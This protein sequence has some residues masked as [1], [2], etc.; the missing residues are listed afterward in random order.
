MED[1]HKNVNINI[2]TGAILKVVFAVLLVFAAFKLSTL[3]LSIL[4]AIVIASFVNFAVMKVR[5]FI[6]NRTFA[7]FLIYIITIGIIVGLSSVFIPV[8]V[9]EMST[10]VSQISNYLPNSSILNTFQSDSISGAKEV[11]G[12]ISHNG[13]L[14]EVIKSTKNL[15]DTFSGGLVD[16]IGVAFGGILYLIITFIISFYLSIKEDGIE[17]FLRV[18]LPQK[19]EEYVISVWKRAEL[20]IGLWMQGQ[21]LVGLIIGVLTYLG[22]TIIGVDYSLVLSIF[23][24]ICLLIPFGIFIALPVASVFAYLGGGVTI[25]SLTILFY[26]ILQ[27]FESYLITPLII[28]KV[29]GVSS[30]V[31]ILAVLIGA[32]LVGIWGVL[33]A[34]PF[35]V[36]LLEVF[37]DI[38]KKKTIARKA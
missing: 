29:T 7:V 23:T 34:V 12:T 20:K 35:S 15:I 26:L 5:N 28:K 1:L 25:T 11:V 27:Q 19:Q 37:D 33:L 10:L 32:E 8:F 38:E 4:T 31:V 13:S 30:L 21:M 18:I 3:I 22:L 17:N 24:A 6:K 36:T 16:I 9:D 2:S 14:G